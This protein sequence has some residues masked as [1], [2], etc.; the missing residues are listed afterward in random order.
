[1][2]FHSPKEL[3][4]RAIEVIVILTLEKKTFLTPGIWILVQDHP[5][6][7]QLN[8]GIIEQSKNKYQIKQSHLPIQHEKFWTSW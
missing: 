8:Y 5:A 3:G 7:S 2:N 4:T 1:M 6:K